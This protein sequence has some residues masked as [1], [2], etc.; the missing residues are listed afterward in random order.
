MPC[1]WHLQGKSRGDVKYA[2]KT[3]SKRCASNS[4]LNALLEDGIDVVNAI[5]EKDT[6]G[7]GSNEWH[8]NGWRSG[9]ALSSSIGRSDTATV[10]SQR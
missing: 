1:E 2:V 9:N 8:G 7:M 5:C 4:R 3:C 6:S 10:S